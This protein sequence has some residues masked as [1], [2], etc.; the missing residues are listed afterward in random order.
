MAQKGITPQAVRSVAAMKIPCKVCLAASGPMY[1]STHTEP[2]RKPV[3]PGH[4][5][6]DPQMRKG[7]KWLV[8]YDEYTRV[9][10][11]RPI[12]SKERHSIVGALKW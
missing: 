3:E 6:I 5:H 12:E 2:R 8:M 4:I 10:R 9:V 11:C 1:P 7:L